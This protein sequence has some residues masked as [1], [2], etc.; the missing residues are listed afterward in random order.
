MIQAWLYLDPKKVD[1][2][3][4]ASLVRNEIENITFTVKTLS[5]INQILLEKLTDFYYYKQN[6]FDEMGERKILN[7]SIK[8][9]T[10]LQK[11]SE[12]NKSQARLQPI[13][14]SSNAIIP[15]GQESTCRDNL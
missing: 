2:E 3:I 13:I 7:Q 12:L 8:D 10:S 14:G 11:D 1:Q 6:A 15:N 9:Y 5:K 4:K